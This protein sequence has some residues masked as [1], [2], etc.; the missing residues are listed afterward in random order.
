MRTPAFPLE[1]DRTAFVEIP[2]IVA[3]ATCHRGEVCKRNIGR[4][5]PVRSCAITPRDTG[6]IVPVQMSLHPRC[7]CAQGKL[8]FSPETAIDLTHLQYC[9]RHHGETTAAHENRCRGVMSDCR[10]DVSELD[11]ERCATT[12]RAIIRVAQRNAHQPTIPIMEE[13]L[14]RRVRITHPTEVQNGHLVPARTQRFSNIIDANGGDGGSDKIGVHEH[15]L[16]GFIPRWQRSQPYPTCCSL[17]MQANKSAVEVVEMRG[18]PSRLGLIPTHSRGEKNRCHADSSDL[19]PVRENIPRSRNSPIAP[20]SGVP[21]G[22]RVL[23]RLG[24]WDMGRLISGRAVE[25]TRGGAQ[26]EET[27][28]GLRYGGMQTTR[29]RM[30]NRE[31]WFPLV[32]HPSL[33]THSRPV[34]PGQPKS[35]T[36]RMRWMPVM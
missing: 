18:S 22:N 26:T 20:A 8:S 21:L 30:L 23:G 17:L 12:E 10:N 3:P 9:L 32:I 14:D 29:Y 6:H 2:G 1:T 24:N 31:R 16:H 33:S 28:V 35:F 34:S 15:G 25:R 27:A 36:E 13:T 19:S 7:Y 11:K 4:S 5:L